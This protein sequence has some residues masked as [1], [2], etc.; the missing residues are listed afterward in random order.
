MFIIK[1]RVSLL[2]GQTFFLGQENHDPTVTLIVSLAL[3]PALLSGTVF[4]RDCLLTKKALVTG[5]RRRL[6]LTGTI[7]AATE[8]F[9]GAVRMDFKPKGA[10][11]ASN[12]ILALPMAAISEM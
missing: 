11:R 6:R 2:Q 7:C 8:R 5:R 4:F 12:L 3:R 9:A 10:I 1:S